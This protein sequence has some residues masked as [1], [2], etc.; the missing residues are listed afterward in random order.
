MYK[1]VSS[2]I[3]LGNT[4]LFVPQYFLYVITKRAT[5]NKT[6]TPMPHFETKKNDK[7][8][9]PYVEHVNEKLGACLLILFVKHIYE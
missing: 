6:P 5:L 9:H 8:G 7:K 3:K 2:K 1:I 4:T